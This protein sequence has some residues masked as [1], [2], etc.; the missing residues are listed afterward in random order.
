M[1][2]LDFKIAK[3]AR[4]ALSLSQAVV[5]TDVGIVRPDLSK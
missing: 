4:E 1:Q 2:I 3:A 5:A